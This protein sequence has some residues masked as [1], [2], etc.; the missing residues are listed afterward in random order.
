MVGQHRHPV[1]AHHIPPQHR[2]EMII[3][4]AFY[5]GK[6]LIG[7]AVSLKPDRRNAKCLSNE[8]VP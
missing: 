2:Q 7:A 5:F 4:Q 1:G 8:P 6:V 3:L